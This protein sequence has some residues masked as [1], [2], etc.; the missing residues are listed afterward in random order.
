MWGYNAVFTG[1]V[2]VT[3]KKLHTYFI[4]Y[5]SLKMLMDNVDKALGD[6]IQYLESLIADGKPL[7]DEQKQQYE[8]LYKKAL[9]AFE[10]NKSKQ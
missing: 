8:E 4:R 2:I 9:S 1:L 7:T 6:T 3:A 5:F 10:K